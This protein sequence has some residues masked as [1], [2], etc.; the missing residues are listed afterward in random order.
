MLTKTQ[1]DIEKKEELF[2]DREEL[3]RQLSSIAQRADYIRACKKAK[4]FPFDFVAHYK[5][6]RGNRY[7]ITLTATDKRRGSINPLISIYTILETEEGKYMLRYDIV[8]NHVNIFTPHFFK[9][10][11]ERLLKRDTAS[12]DETIATFARN[13]PNTATLRGGEVQTCTEGYILAKDIDRESSVCVTFISFDMLREEQAETSEGLLEI[14]KKHEEENEI[15]T[16]KPIR[17]KPTA[18][19]MN[20][21]TETNGSTITL[22]DDTEGVGLQFKEGEPLQEYES[23]LV[24]RDFSILETEAGVAHLSEVSNRLHKEAAKRYPIEFQP[25]KD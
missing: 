18:K 24:L 6:T 7:T 11:R 22:W 14:I 3:Q 12:A 21:R 1:T 4:R 20:Y 9:R 2:K 15:Q 16:R 17:T 25:L 23:N 19:T 8:R 5:S 13:N 10:Y